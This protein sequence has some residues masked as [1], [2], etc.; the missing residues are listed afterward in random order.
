[1]NEPPRALPG[2]IEIRGLRIMAT[3]GVLPDEQVHAQPFELDLDIETD[4]STA[5][6]SDDIAAA[7]DY[8]A[9]VTVVSEVVVGRS[10]GLLESLAAAVSDAVLALRGVEAVDVVVRKLAPAI[11]ADVASVGVR[12]ARREEPRA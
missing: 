10:H 5:A 8:A 4:M 11:E 7:V 2:R 9:V 3:H 1:L 12:I 6:A